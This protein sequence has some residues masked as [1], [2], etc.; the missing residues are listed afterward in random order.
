MRILYIALILLTGCTTP[1]APEVQFNPEHEKNIIIQNMDEQQHAWDNGDIEAF[2][3]HY[4][5]HD[6]LVFIGKSGLTYGWQST[7]DNYK[8]SYPDKEAMGRLQFT[9]HVV[10]V[11]DTANAYVIGGWKLFRM[12]DT[13]S[14]HYSLLWKKLDE[15]W[16]IVADHSS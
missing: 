6:S 12:A 13:L 9:N 15:H 14:G 2:M 7:L 8:K 10:E 3:K 11:L 16:V 5:Q 4:W 1:P